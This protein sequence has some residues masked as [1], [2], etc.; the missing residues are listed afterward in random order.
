MSNP[1]DTPVNP[2]NPF[3]HFT[4]EPEP[5]PSQKRVKAIARAMKTLE[6]VQRS[7]RKANPYATPDRVEVLGHLTDAI[8]HC[9]VA[10]NRLQ[11]PR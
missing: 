5:T 7:I 8:M 10:I 11:N 6:T 3:Q 9:S 2:H 4:P 1:Y